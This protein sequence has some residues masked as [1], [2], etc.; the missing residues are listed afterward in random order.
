MT[1]TNM[2]SDTKINDWVPYENILKVG[3]I[4]T[5][6]NPPIAALKNKCGVIKGIDR[7]N[8]KVLLQI[9]PHSMRVDI[10]NITLVS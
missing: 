4:V 5:I 3:D 2:D 6:D 9:G 1:E 10:F 8:D 7:R